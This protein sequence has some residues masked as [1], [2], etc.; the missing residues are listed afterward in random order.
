MSMNSYFNI[1]QLD[2]NLNIIDYSE[3][4]IPSYNLILKV[5]LMS[6][7]FSDF[8]NIKI[9]DYDIIS[10][11]NNEYRNNYLK[12]LILNSIYILLIMYLEI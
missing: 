1:K 3:E 8:N 11:S 12:K 6:P 10:F 2:K 5:F 4:N 7:V 9:K